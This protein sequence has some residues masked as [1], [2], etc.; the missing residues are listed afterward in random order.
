M[1][2]NLL[3]LSIHCGL[4]GAPW[5]GWAAPNVWEWDRF[6]PAF[7]VTPDPAA[8]EAA[9][10]PRPSVE[11]W[12]PRHVRRMHRHLPGATTEASGSARIEGTI[13][14]PEAPAHD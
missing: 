1:N 3:A 7:F 2:F 14:A 5:D 4:G 13:T 11:H 10:G 9:L 12:A 8:E 6:H